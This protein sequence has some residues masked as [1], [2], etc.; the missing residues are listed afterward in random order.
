LA[1][2]GVGNCEYSRSEAVLSTIAT[3][4]GGASSIAIAQVA[5]PKSA[6]PGMC[7]AEIKLDVTLSLET[8]TSPA[9]AINISS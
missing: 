5:F 4:T 7:P 1:I 8:D 2:T 6:G 3:D 9:N